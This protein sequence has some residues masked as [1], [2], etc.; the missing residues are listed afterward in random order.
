VKGLSS[1]CIPDQSCFSLVGKTNCLDVRDLVAFFDEFLRSLFYAG[2]DRRE[3]F[4][5]VVLVPTMIC[6]N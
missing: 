4:P 6:I 1:L 3:E 2:F 5:G